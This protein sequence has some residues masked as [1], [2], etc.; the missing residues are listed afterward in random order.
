[1]ID[2]KHSFREIMLIVIE[3]VFVQLKP[4]YNT[5]TQAAVLKEILRINLSENLSYHPLEP[6]FT[7]GYTVIRKL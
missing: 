3:S 6:V 4:G 2:K 5:I 7:H 1:M